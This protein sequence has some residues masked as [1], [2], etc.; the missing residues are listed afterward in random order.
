MV[1]CLGSCPA[2]RFYRGVLPRFTPAVC[3]IAPNRTACGV[4]RSY[5]AG[6]DRHLCVLAVLVRLSSLAGS[7]RVCA[8]ICGDL[9]GV[10]GDTG[11][12][13]NG[14]TGGWRRG[15]YALLR[16]HIGFAV[17]SAGST[18]GATRPQTCAKESSTLWTLFTLRRGCVG[19]NTHPCKKRQRS[20]QRIH[21]CKARVHGKTRPALIYGRAGRA[22]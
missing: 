17:L 18:L 19:A 15:L 14:A 13:G 12:A 8:F 9:D 10:A 5:S 4:L 6:R 20:N 1:F 2:M 22:V 16:N 7:L 21:A 11:D 3:R